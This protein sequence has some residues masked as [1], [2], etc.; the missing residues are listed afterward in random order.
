MTNEDDFLAWTTIPNWQHAT[1]VGFKQPGLFRFLLKGKVMFLGYAA[2]PKTGLGACITA[3]RRGAAFTQSAGRR[4]FRQQEELELQVALLDW[5][6]VEIRDLCK[7]MIEA[8]RPPW[9]ARHTYR[10]RF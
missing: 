10:G 1:L 8:D 5:P 6:S 3:Y 9:N 4:I 7:D 2:S